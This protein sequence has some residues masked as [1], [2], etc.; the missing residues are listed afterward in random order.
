MANEIKDIGSGTGKLYVT[1]PASVILRNLTNNISGVRSIINIAST[2]GI[3]PWEIYQ[4]GG[5]APPLQDE[6]DS[7]FGFRFYINADY[8]GA[9]PEGSLVAAVEITKYIV[10]K[11]LQ[12]NISSQI[13]TLVG[14]VLTVTRKSVFTKIYVDTEGGAP[15]DFLDEITAGEFIEGD[16]VV[17]AGVAAG[18]VSTLRDVGVTAKNIHLAKTKECELGDEAISIILQVVK[19]NLATAAIF[20]E[21]SRTDDLTRTVADIRAEGL[22]AAIGGVDTQTIASIAG[23]TTITL[24]P[25]TSKQVLQITGGPTNIT[26][27]IVITT[28]GTPINGDSFVVMLDALS[29]YTGAFTITIFGI[30]LTAAQALRGGY[31]FEAVFDTA[32][33]RVNMI[34][35]VRSISTSG[36]EISY[37]KIPIS[38][39][40]TQTLFSVGKDV[41]GG[42]EVNQSI[43]IIDAVCDMD[44][45][46]GTPYATDGEMALICTGA[47]AP[48]FTI[49]SNNFLF[50]TVARRIHMVRH[51]SA[52]LVTDTMIVKGAGIRLEGN[53]AADATANGSAWVLHIWYTIMES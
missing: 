3:I 23:G 33:Y 11:G 50:G 14:G 41:L 18:R 4:N 5:A 27:N 2:V 32:S 43:K 44:V 12:S 34:N 47:N 48:Q 19:P 45:Y 39:G 36:E 28:G 13:A 49:I 6:Y 22:P 38:Q 15:T 21:V 37:V 30:T 52:L 29:N 51:N 35:D 9:A 7:N 20:V 26:G 24:V 42:L 46:N 10:N 16:F 8:A 25:G 53:G 1:T 31:R 17:I 40:E